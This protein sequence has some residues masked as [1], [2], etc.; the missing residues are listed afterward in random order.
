MSNWKE[1]TASQYYI[2]D[3][4]S[5]VY[6]TL[7]CALE[8][9]ISDKIFRKDKSRVFLSSNEYAFR[10]RFELLASKSN[11]SDIDIASLQFPF[12]NYWP[13]N[14]GW[15]TEKRIA[16][17]PC[18]L[19]ETGICMGTTKLRAIMSTINVPITFYFDRED[20]ARLAYEILYF[21][22]YI[23]RYT[24][25]TIGYKGNV[26]R[27]PM[28]I[29]VNSLSFNPKNNE[30][31]WLTNNRI[32][33]VSAELLL[34]SFVLKP[35]AQ[36]NYSISMNTDGTLSDGTQYDDGVET[37]YL[38]NEVLLQMK[39]HKGLITSTLSVTGSAIDTNIYLNKFD[40][41]D[42]TD[43]SANLIWE[44]EDPTIISKIELYE[45]STSSPI[46]VPISGYSFVN[47]Q[48]S[49]IYS[50]RVIFYSTNNT[51]KIMYYSFDT[52]VAKSEDNDIIKKDTKSLIGTSW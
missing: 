38:T 12:A 30:T 17:N 18:P 1:I 29:R 42:I 25:T 26:L 13:Q 47:L 23:E 14:S 22:S 35:P 8:N 39:D 5:K 21:S 49:S 44:C 24:S 3:S 51:S 34:R 43:N 4:Y 28:N 15:E 37:F 40:V 48:S 32:F 6:Y 36:P 33:I 16:A 10:R 2:Q 11:Y 46:D 7:Y 41:E 50:G 9:W 20:D 52:E 19:V 31:T 27:L 45:N